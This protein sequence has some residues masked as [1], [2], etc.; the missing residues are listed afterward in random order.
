MRCWN[1]FSSSCLPFIQLSVDCPFLGPLGLSFLTV[2][3]VAGFQEGFLRGMVCVCFLP[4][5]LELKNFRL[6]QVM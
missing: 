3:L 4:V 1:L 2:K 6:D 5:V